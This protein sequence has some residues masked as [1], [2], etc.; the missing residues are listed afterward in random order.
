MASSQP[1]PPDPSGNGSN[2]RPKG[3]W[4]QT[5]K[6]KGKRPANQAPRP[7]GQ[8]Q[9]TL[10]QGP[11]AGNKRDREASNNPF[12]ALEDNGAGLERDAESEA[13]DVGDETFEG[14]VIDKGGHQVITQ[15]VL[16]AR[17]QKVITAAR[18]QQMVN[19][20]Y[21][22]GNLEFQ[23]PL[24]SRITDQYAASDRPPRSQLDY[25]NPAGQKFSVDV[26]APAMVILRN[27][28][29]VMNP[30]VVQ[31]A[32]NCLLSRGLT[33]PSIWLG[34]HMNSQNP[35]IRLTIKTRT[36]DV[37]AHIFA[38]SILR[39]FTVDAERGRL[40]LDA[41]WGTQS[42]VQRSLPA[43]MP[44]ELVDAAADKNL[45]EFALS[46]WPRN[47]PSHVPTGPRPGPVRF[48]GI[49]PTAVNALREQALASPQQMTEE[50][51]LIAQLA[52]IGEGPPLYLS[53]FR[54]WRS[55]AAPQAQNLV[56]WLWAA[57]DM[58]TTVD[59]YWFYHLQARDGVGAGQ[60][61]Y[62]AGFPLEK[63]DKPRWLAQD[64]IA[65]YDA[66]GKIH[67]LVDIGKCNSFNLGN[68]E[69]CYATPAEGAFELRLATKRNAGHQ[70][71]ILRSAF[72]SKNDI[73]GTFL[74]SPDCL[75]MFFVKMKVKEGFLLNK[76]RSLRPASGTRLRLEV[77]TDDEQ[78]ITLKG[79][80]CDDYFDSK[81]DACAAVSGRD[82]VPLLKDWNPDGHDLPISVELVDDP[83]PSNRWLSSIEM[84]QFE[85]EEWANTP[86]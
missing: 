77:V 47:R 21:R 5:D 44:K 3:N 86:P 1:T 71:R 50:E 37:T 79:T 80:I 17:H 63:L 42:A 73:I 55:D 9:Q 54:F 56:K 78:R 46:L 26:N 41:N 2:G 76:D 28:P 61:I 16:A 62:D 7:P 10:Q 25:K 6:S 33:E 32:G 11:W 49:T 60:S 53:I 84:I 83:T 48:T 38:S 66:G 35:A 57:F 19:V 29:S 69:S 13:M 4:Q 31:G 14:F 22:P 75:T 24:G 74:Q 67:G 27:R 70:S 36:Q 64:F 39:D 81:A 52:G 30:R 68:R 58:S 12:D 20:N 85:A 18:V 40:C 65:E 59:P 43:G 72:N 45:L 34:F 23:N 8:Q 15:Q 51:Y 82:I